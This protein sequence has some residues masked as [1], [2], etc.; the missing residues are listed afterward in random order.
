M[1]KSKYFQTLMIE[2]RKPLNRWDPI[3]EAVADE[4][5]SKYTPIKLLHLLIK[6][7]QEQN[8]QRF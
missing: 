8:E 4:L 2:I 6:I 7:I 3:L 5:D 1:H